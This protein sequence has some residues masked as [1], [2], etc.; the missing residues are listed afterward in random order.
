M[1]Y[2]YHNG[3]AILISCIPKT[4][5]VGDIIKSVDKTAEHQNKLCHSHEG[6]GIILVLQ[7]RKPSNFYVP[8]FF[9]TN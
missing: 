6:F 3:I 2:I 5:A 1:L 8:V 9:L 4:S 7:N